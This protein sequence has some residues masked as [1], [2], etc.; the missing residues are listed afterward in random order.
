[1]NTPNTNFSPPGI[2]LIQPNSEQALQLQAVNKLSAGLMRSKRKYSIELLDM[3][4]ERAGEIGLAAAAE[5]CCIGYEALK[6]H[7]YS[8]KIERQKAGMI[9]VKRAHNSKYSME[10]KRAVV[11]KAKEIRES[12]GITLSKAFENAGRLYGA[13]GATIHRAYNRGE[14]IM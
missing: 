7:A 10:Q 12:T 3:G 5:E 13:N 6:K 9:G 14:I 4:V 8:R 1:M 11:L 2:S